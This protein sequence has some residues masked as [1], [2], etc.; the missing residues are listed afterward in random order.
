[1]NPIVMR[2]LLEI[3]ATAGEQDWKPFHAG[4]ESL[5]IYETPQGGPAA[6]LLR[7]QPGAHAPPHVHQGYEHILILSGSQTDEQGYHP[8]GSLLIHPPGTEHH[9]H[10]EDGCVVLAIWERR[11]R[12]IAD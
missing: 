7:Y 6:M 1:M 4:I 11:V 3:A 5:T 8:A 9:V 10:S 2:G 12:F